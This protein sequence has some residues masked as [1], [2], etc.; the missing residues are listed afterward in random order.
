MVWL[1]VAVTS[2]LMWL[3]AQLGLKDP[4]NPWLALHEYD[5]GLH[6]L[7]IHFTERQAVRLITRP[8]FFKFTFVRNP[9]SR[10]ASAYSNKLVKS[11]TPGKKT[12]PG[13]RSYWNWAFFP[14]RAAPV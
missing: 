8:D 5:S 6:Q 13:S 10:A 7:A 2:W 12:G 9:F 14:Q 3:R 4:K 1:Q 11:D